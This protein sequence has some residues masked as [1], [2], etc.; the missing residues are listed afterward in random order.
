MLT[1]FGFFSDNRSPLQAIAC[2]FCGNKD[3]SGAGLAVAAFWLG[4]VGY[5][6][7]RQL[8]I[9]WRRLVKLRFSTK[10]PEVGCRPPK[11][12]GPIE[13]TNEQRSSPQLGHVEPGG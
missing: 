6:A 4:L 2:I 9:F 11:G 8:R 5:C 12:R 10:T 7:Y 3:H 13:F 1:I